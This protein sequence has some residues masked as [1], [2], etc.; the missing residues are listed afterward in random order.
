MKT[1]DKDILQYVL[2]K[3]YHWAFP[4]GYDQFQREMDFH[5]AL[6]DIALN[7]IDSLEDFVSSMN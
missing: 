1:K 7:Q 5:A 4:N 6:E 2:V 3:L